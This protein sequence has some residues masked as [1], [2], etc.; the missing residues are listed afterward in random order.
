VDADADP[1]AAPHTALLPVNIRFGNTGDGDYRDR[2]A[3]PAGR[4]NCNPQPATR[5]RRSVS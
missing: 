4:S 2:L 1:T 5:Q 3:T